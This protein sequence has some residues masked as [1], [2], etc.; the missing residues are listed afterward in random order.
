MLEFGGGSSLS[1]QEQQH[2]LPPCICHHKA[3]RD[4]SSGMTSWPVWKVEQ[5]ALHGSSCRMTHMAGL[6]LL[7]NQPAAA[8]D[9][10]QRSACQHF[11]VFSH[12][13]TFAM[14]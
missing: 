6:R 12:I 10:L 11:E 8:A 13:M 7:L 3:L 4:G 9:F 5:S 14:T 2:G 1:A